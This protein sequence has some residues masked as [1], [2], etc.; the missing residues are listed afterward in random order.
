MAG[1]GSWPAIHD[2][3]RVAGHGANAE[4]TE[5]SSRGDVRSQARATGREPTVAGTEHRAERADG[6]DGLRTATV[7]RATGGR[8]R[9]GDRAALPSAGANRWPA[10]PGGDCARR[11][12]VLWTQG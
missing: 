9:P 3:R 7:A 1:R 5:R 12:P 4:P 10:Q 8:I 6:R 2:V 11:L